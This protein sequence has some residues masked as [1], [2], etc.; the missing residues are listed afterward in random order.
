MTA[1]AVDPTSPAA[2]EIAASGGDRRPRDRAGL[3]AAVAL[4]TAFA[5]LG[6]IRH[7]NWWSGAIDLGVF[8]Q[9]I[10]LLSRGLAPEVTINGRNL[11]ADHLSPIVLVFV[12]LYRLYATPYWLFLGQG[13]ALGASVLPLRALARHEGVPPWVATAT[14]ALG[15]PLS[16]AAMF[17]F[18]PATL[19]VP[20]V[21]WAALAVR[22]DDTR[23]ATIAGLL[24][25]ACRA[26]LAWVLIG[27]AIVAAPA[28]RR[29]LAALAGVGV[30]AGFAIPAALGARGTFTV[31]FG[32]L[33]SSPKDALLHPWRIA[34]ALLSADTV[35]KAL[36][37]LLPVAFLTA[38]RPRW[39]AATAVASLPVLL[40]QWPGTSMPWFHYWAPMYPLAVAGALVALGAPDRPA[41][42]RPQVL[43][44]GGIA[45]VLLFGPLSP[46]APD[47]V[48]WRA[49]TDHRTDRERAA[50]QVGPDEPVVA[51]NRILAHLT[52]R[53]EAWLFP[54]PYAAGDPA[55]LGPTPSPAAARRIVTA[56]LEGDD[57]AR[58]RA[59]GII[60][61]TLDGI[62]VAHPQAPTP[63][64]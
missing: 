43:V 44:A 15:T 30:V 32:H 29:R 26:E 49:L 11:F 48:G 55:E 35:T 21:A 39:L 6:A 59:F 50:A 56:V 42:L 57:I 64:G 54:S 37:L 61:A 13:I 28:L 14:V 47:T 1:M 25:L 10:W 41:W 19:A 58:A 46:R 3:I 22:R 17:E 40:S 24:I 18:H 27:L 31:H 16:A 20:F 60:G 62:L 52:H 9:G 4:G 45:A 7:F 34:E 36:I 33:G 8:D 51:S 2:D 5:A 12:P 38:A 63:G 53:R 23:T